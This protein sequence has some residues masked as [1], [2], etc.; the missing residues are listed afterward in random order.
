MN[1]DESIQEEIGTV[2]VATLP[3][4]IK[5]RLLDV[6][7]AVTAAVVIVYVFVCLFD[8]SN[9]PAVLKW[10]HYPGL[11][12]GFIALSA[13]FVVFVFLLMFFPLILFFF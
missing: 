13:A 2:H 10:W 1:E 9:K 11:V 12:A 8:F 6:G 7:L 5:D 3:E 4:V